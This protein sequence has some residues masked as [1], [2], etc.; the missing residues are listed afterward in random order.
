MRRSPRPWARASRW[1]GGGAAVAE[2][3]VDP[4]GLET[5]VEEQGR[6]HG[7]VHPAAQGHGYTLILVCHFN[8]D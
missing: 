1:A 7:A 4:Q 5:L 8:N 3:E 2:T 6:G